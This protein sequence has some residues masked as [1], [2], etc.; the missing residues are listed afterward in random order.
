MRILIEP[1]DVLMF[2]ESKPYIAGEGHLARSIFPLPQAIAGALRSKIL[3]NPKD[4][5]ISKEKLEEFISIVREN[6][7]KKIRIADPEFEILG[8]FL[9]KDGCEYFSTPLDIAKAKD[10]DGYFSVKPLF[11]GHWNKFIFKGESIHFES[12]GGFID[13]DSLVD[14]LKGEM[15]EELEEIV[16]HD[17]IFR[18]NRVGI[19]L[20]N[21]KT[22]E[23]GFFYKAEFL[24][25]AKGVGLSVWIGKN[26]KRLKELLGDKGLIRL[27]G[28]SRFVR[29]KVS[30]VN[31]T[32]KLEEVW[33]DIKE[34]INSKKKFKLYVATPLLIKNRDYYTLDIKSLLEG[35]LNITI[36]N[37]Y[38]LIGKPIAFSGWD[39]ANN[40]PKPSRY[41]V[42]SGSVYFIEFN[43]EPN[44]SKPYLNLGN[45]KKLG[46]GLCFMGVW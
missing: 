40:C 22:T 5:T 44:L 45:L 14:Y 25:L 17:L 42:P 27:G 9:F 41:A 43:G 26:S 37:F 39:Y 2:R 28:E 46:Y 36:K 34:D 1:N 10:I 13:Y 19:K 4:K 24:R 16:E 38:P 21:A 3:L 6:E 33:D 30:D 12:V 23:E 31:P 18:E 29:F 20:E 11:L 32:S 35:K 8:H 15:E 7:N